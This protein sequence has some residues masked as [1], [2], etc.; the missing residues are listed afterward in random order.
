MS[1]VTRPPN[2]LLQ[3]L[4]SAEYAQLHPLLETVEL[5]KETALADAGVQRAIDGATVRKV[6]V[7]APKLVSI[8][9]E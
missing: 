4:P 7:R 6:I 2:R 1:A 9:P 5:T 3:A 8:V